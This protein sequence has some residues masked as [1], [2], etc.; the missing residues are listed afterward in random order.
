MRTVI[1][2]AA[3]CL[4]GLQAKLIAESRTGEQI[5]TAHCATCHSIGVANAPKL[6]DRAAWE[7]RG[8]S[9]DEFVASSKKGLNAMPPNGTCMDCTDQELKDSIQYMM[10]KT[11]EN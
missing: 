6:N 10:G 5:Y 8:K 1:I 9:M 11:K 2:L 3:L 4:I 7:A